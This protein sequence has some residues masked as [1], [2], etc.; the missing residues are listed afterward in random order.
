MA[1]LFPNQWTAS[2]DVTRL[3]AGEPLLL[4]DLNRD[5]FRLVTQEPRGATEEL[6]VAST[7]PLDTALRALREVATRSGTAS[8]PVAMDDPAAIVGNLLTDVSTTR[9]NPANAGVQTVDVS[10]LAALSL[11]FDVL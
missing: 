10:E 6:I 7:H 9:G 3:G 1:V 4:P 2:A 8:G 11:T 5:S